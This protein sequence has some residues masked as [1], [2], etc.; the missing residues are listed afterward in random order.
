MLT[1]D[2]ARLLKPPVT[3]R[4]RDIGC[5]RADARTGD[6]LVRLP[7]LTTLDLYYIANCARLDFLPQLA[8]LSTLE[9]YCHNG[10]DQW[11][12][13]AD[14]LLSSLALCNGLTELTLTC[15]FRSAHWSGLFAKLT[16]L[17]KLEICRGELDTLMCFAAGPITQ[18]LE[19]LIIQNLELT[20]PPAEISHLYA[21]RR[22]SHLILNCCFSSA[23]DAETCDSLSPPTPVLPALANLFLRWRNPDRSCEE[24]LR[25]D[26]SFEWMQRR[27]AQ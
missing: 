23:V 3:A 2:L 11:H 15:G 1:D 21:L 26:A 20:L 25:R 14:A 16:K 7:T 8:L 13:P 12:I 24:V 5:V 17:R 18:S 27:L 6:L 4:W 22:L 10:A 19:D 9:L